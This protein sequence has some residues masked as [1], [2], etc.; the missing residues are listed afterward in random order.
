VVPPRL[1][2]IQVVI[3]PIYRSADERARVFDGAAAVA[4]ALRGTHIRV[5]VDGRDNLKPGPK[6]Y[7]WERKGVPVRI[8]IGPKDVANQQLTV[9]LRA[10]P[11]ELQRKQAWP[12][13]SA[14]LMMPDLL[15]QLQRGL[16]RAALERREANSHRAVASYAALRELIED[17]GGFVFAGWCGSTECEQ[18]V[19][20]E[21]KATIRV[22][23]LEEFR[24]AEPPTTCVVCGAG[25]ITEAV[26]ARAY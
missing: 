11:G 26:W 23:P 21:T 24:T 19:K 13:T 7:E 10:T 12:A 4:S 6:F 1:A 17:V 5:H 20:D 3:V 18:K 25:A 14:A 16:Y 9:V 15:E 22:L 2:P 8:E